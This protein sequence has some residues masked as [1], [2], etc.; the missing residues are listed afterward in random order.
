MNQSNTIDDRQLVKCMEI[1]K[2][3]DNQLR[4]Q[5]L[6]IYHSK[7]LLACRYNDIKQDIAEELASLREE[8]A[9]LENVSDQIFVSQPKDIGILHYENQYA[10]NL[11]QTQ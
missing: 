1:H 5:Y 6:T 9:T 10:I 2:K 8:G 7:Y 11:Q 4:N 3:I